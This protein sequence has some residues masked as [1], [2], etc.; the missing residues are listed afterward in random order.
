MKKARNDYKDARI[1][2]REANQRL[3]SDLINK[4]RIRSREVN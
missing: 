2:S 1:R 3:L 4:Q